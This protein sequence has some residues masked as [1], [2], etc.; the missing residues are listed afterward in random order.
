MEA[1]QQFLQYDLTKLIIPV[2][3]LM[4][5][6][7]AGYI[8][9]RL[10]FRSLRRWAISTKTRTDDI[11]IHAFSGPLMIWVLILG[12]FAAT[13]LSELRDSAAA[14]ISKTLLILWIGS[15]TIVVSR[16]AG[17]L[18]KYY[19]SRMQ[20]ALP[21]TSLTQ[22]LARIAIFTIG[23]LIVLNQL[24]LSIAPIL[25]ALGVGGLAVALALQDTLSNLFAGF[26]VS[27]AG[28]IRPGDYI[29]LDSGGEGYVAD[30]TWRSTTVKT[31]ANNLIIV[32]NAKLAQ[33]IIT[34][35]H[36]PAR[37]IITRLTIS[38]SYDSALEQ[39][40]QILFQEAQTLSRERP[41][42]ITM[43]EPVVRL[44]PGF[45]DSSL[46]FTLYYEV[47]DIEQQTPAQDELR[48]RIFR[49]FRDI[50]IEIPFPTRTVQWRS[51][52]KQKT[53]AETS[54][55]SSQPPPL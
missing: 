30:I 6:V 41:D 19:G 14:K 26:Y 25:T 34:N 35:Y 18:I 53:N 2:I 10:L 40:E 5:I 43:R 4:T 50:G 22:N 27:L 28:H 8:A 23:F 39:V 47:P 44:V 17:N 48:R 29:Q 3:V 52:F 33:A 9:Q 45:G 7:I 38:V 13:Q 54:P 36:L 51:D 24:G 15:L 20:G 49:R 21:V 16:L 31:P 12:I 42:L 55:N 32:P 11:V 46:D 1:V 37:N